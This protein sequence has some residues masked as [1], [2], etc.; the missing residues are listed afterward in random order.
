[1]A[2][3]EGN[4]VTQG[5]FLRTVCLFLESNS[6]RELAQLILEQDGAMTDADEQSLDLHLNALFL[7]RNNASALLTKIHLEMESLEADL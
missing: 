3:S 5:C 4:K 7:T 6:G 2:N 1:M